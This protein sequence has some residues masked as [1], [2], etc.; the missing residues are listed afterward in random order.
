MLAQED[1]LSA[2][3]WTLLGKEEKN[4]TGWVTSPPK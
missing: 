2:E 3:A 1:Q 4:I